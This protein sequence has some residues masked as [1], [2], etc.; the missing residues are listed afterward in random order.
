MGLST[1][2]DFISPGIEFKADTNKK[3]PAAA[4]FD[5]AT[6]GSGFSTEEETSLLKIRGLVVAF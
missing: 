3:A 4:S 1:K 6:H 2:S 5:C